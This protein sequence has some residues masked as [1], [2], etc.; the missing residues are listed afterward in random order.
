MIRKTRPG[1]HANEKLRRRSEELADEKNAHEPEFSDVDTQ[2]LIHE[3]RVH[4][5][6][7]E[8]Q[9]EELREAQSELAL[10][11]DR[12]LEL[13]DFAPIGYFTLDNKGLIEKVNL[14]GAEL[15]GFNRAHLIRKRFSSFIAPDSQD[16]FYFH[17]QKVLM[18][19]DRQVCELELVNNNGVQ[20]YAQLQTV[21]HDLLNTTHLC[22][23]A[24]DITARINFEKQLEAANQELEQRVADRTSELTEANLALQEEV[25]QRTRTEKSLHALSHQLIRAQECERQMISRE[26]HDRLGQD[27]SILKIGFDDLRHEAKDVCPGFLD[28]MASLSNLMQKT[29]T[30]IRDLAYE[31]RPPG[32][33]QIGFERTI[34]QYTEDF[35]KRTGIEVD[36]KMTGIKDLV[37]DFDI[38]INLYRLIQESLNN[39][40]KH[41]KAKRVVI[42]M[43]ASYPSLILRIEDDGI[44]FDSKDRFLTSVREKSMGLRNMQERAAL[45]GG[46]VSIQSQP[47][48]GTRIRIEVP[49]LRRKDD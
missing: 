2:K 13:Y 45:L 30:G 41:A 34:I 46:K 4:Q 40:Q 47:G 35:C 26:L 44:G 8:L 1:E 16:V 7:L 37:L 29:I 6:E 23:A 31:L 39:I 21:A 27:I 11:R 10:S 32:L 24:I 38:E 33:D 14:A 9:N 19:Q 12:Y 15:L 48:K 17:R 28:R 36:M 49:C 22:I 25:V 18:S 3:L 43:V 20:F 5:I 42:K